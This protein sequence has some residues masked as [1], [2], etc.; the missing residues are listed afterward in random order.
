M[1]HVFYSLA[2]VD[3]IFWCSFKEWLSYGPPWPTPRPKRPKCQA[4]FLQL[5]AAPD[6]NNAILV[7]FCWGNIRQC[8]SVIG[9]SIMQND[10]LVCSRYSLI[11]FVS[12]VSRKTSCCKPI[13][14]NCSWD[15]IIPKFM[16]RRFG[17]S[18]WDSHWFQT[19][20]IGIRGTSVKPRRTKSPKLSTNLLR[21]WRRT[22]AIFFSSS[23]KTS[24]WVHMD[25]VFYLSARGGSQIIPLKF[26]PT[27]IQM[28][29]TY[30]GTIQAAWGLTSNLTSSDHIGIG[31]R[32]RTFDNFCW[33]I[34][35]HLL[36]PFVNFAL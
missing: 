16:L 18:S 22:L 25:V 7:E 3:L 17:W 28:F 10:V 13:V 27:N 35:M 1:W 5:N 32:I 34:Y 33:C 23:C 30:T 8:D 9:P 26:D 12:F 36:I 2:R 15:P 21:S 20:K 24:D 11:W 29:T 19:T 4:E 14:A 6:G 31:L